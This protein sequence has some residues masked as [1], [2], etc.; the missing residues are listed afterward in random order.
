MGDTIP[1]NHDDGGVDRR[2]RLRRRPLRRPDQRQP[3]PAFVLR[4]GDI[5]Q[6]S[7]PGEFDTADRI[8]GRIRTDR[9][10]FVP[11]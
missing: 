7:Q 6:L 9:I 3:R 8:I 11:G 1:H 2:G 10:F 5:S 4:T